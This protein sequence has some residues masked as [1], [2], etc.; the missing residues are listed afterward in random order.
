MSP[1]GIEIKVGQRW[2]ELDPRANRVVKIVGIYPQMSR[3]PIAVRSTT[4][5]RLAYNDTGRFTGKRGGYKLE[6]EV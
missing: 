2:R 4:T 3:R 6:S 1:C 5:G